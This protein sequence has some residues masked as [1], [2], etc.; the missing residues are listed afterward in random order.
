MPRA[1]IYIGDGSSRASLSVE[2]FQQLASSLAEQ[3]IPL[4]GYAV[5]PNVDKQLLGSLAVQTGGVVIDDKSG[6]SAAEAGRALAAA[7]NAT[8][9]WPGAVKWPAEI[10]EVFPKTLPPLRSDRDTV[11]VG[12]LKGKDA[13]QIEAP[14][15]GPGGRKTLTWNVAAA[16]SNDDNNYLGSLV[17]A[18]RVAGGVDLPLVGSASLEDAKRQIQAGG[19]GLTQFAR[20]ALTAGN[21][22]AADKL[23]AEASAA[24]RAI[25][26]R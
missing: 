8:V 10:G 24:I 11:V 3:R 4:S 6:A 19:R 18:A 2:K 1:A 17:E 5:G 23:A 26:R 13:M 22:N 15:E 16:K 7:A 25:R 14:V 20:Q 12:T 21:L 9:F